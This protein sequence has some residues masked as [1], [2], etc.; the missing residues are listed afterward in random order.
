[1]AVR[2]VVGKVDVLHFYW[3]RVNLADFNWMGS[4]TCSFNLTPCL[5]S[6]QREMNIIKSFAVG[7]AYK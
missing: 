5:F 1:M 6:R 4:M 7:F 3:F 2:L